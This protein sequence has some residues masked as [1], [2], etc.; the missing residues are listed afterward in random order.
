MENVWQYMRQ[1][2]LSNRVF[3]TYSDILDAGCAAWNKLIEQR[4]TI[5]TIGSRTWAHVGRH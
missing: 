2:W 1:T 5:R 4:E 3:E